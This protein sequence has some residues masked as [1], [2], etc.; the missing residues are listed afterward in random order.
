MNNAIHTLPASINSALEYA[1][2]RLTEMYGDRISRV[3]LYGSHARSEAGPESDV[4]VLVVLRTEFDL[5]DELK[6]LTR[7]KLHLL[8]RF[9]TYVSFQAFAEVA[10]QDLRR[11]FMRNVHAEGI[12]L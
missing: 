4:D 5:Y 8:E 11:P 3:I 10:Y 7:L 2:V 12:V 1:R 6:R 9:D